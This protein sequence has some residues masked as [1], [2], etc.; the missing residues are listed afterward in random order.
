MIEVP[1]NIHDIERDRKRFEAGKRKI[2]SSDLILDK[3]K[4]DFENYI[5]KKRVKKKVSYGRLANTCSYFYKFCTLFFPNRDLAQL[6]EE[7]YIMMCANLED[8]VFKTEKEKKYSDETISTFK[9][10]FRAYMRVVIGRSETENRFEEFDIKRKKINPKANYLKYEEVKILLDNI[11]FEDYEMRF[12][13]AFMF[14]TG[15]RSQDIRNLRI[16]DIYIDDEGDLMVAFPELKTIGRDIEI[17]EFKPQIEFYL[18]YIKNEKKRNNLD[19]LIS[20]KN[21]KPISIQV[22]NR[23]LKNYSIST[24]GESYDW[25]TSHKLR[26]SSAV[27][28]ASKLGMTYQQYCKKFGWESNSS[29]PALYY[30]KNTLGKTKFKEVLG[31]SKTPVVMVG[32]IYSDI[33]AFEDFGLDL[34]EE[35]FDVWL[36]EITG[37]PYSEN[38]VP[39]TYQDLE[40]YYVP[41]LLGG[42]QYYS[43]ETQVNYIGHSNGCRSALTSLSKYYQGLNDIGYAFDYATGNWISVDLGSYPVDKFFGIAC[44]TTLNEETSVSYYQ[45]KITLSNNYLGDWAIE[46]LSNENKVNIYQDEYVSLVS[47]FSGSKD[48]KI[49]L[50]LQDF[51][52][53]L[54]I[55]K[56]SSFNGNQSVANK[57]L[58]FAGTD[59]IFIPIPHFNW[60]NNN[61]DGVV[62]IKDLELLNNSFLNS[63]LYFINK[64]HRNIIFDNTLNN[65]IEEEL[66]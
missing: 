3:N 56:T 17:V 43:G 55:D 5:L 39:Y 59:E 29:T 48:N 15:C 22:L 14:S 65:I 6:Q 32:G 64:N 38:N 2:M 27:Y 21:N 37:G 40:D 28:F 52:N 13:I 12:I 57:Y 50:N 4:Q 18:H 33:T 11:P 1:V 7:D 66:K 53:D 46:K 61:D 8:G 35:G 42:V 41:A 26:H 30:D 47:P 9:R 36:I 51:Y 25:V 10:F 60:N 44:P 49:S 62:P 63:E 24:F 16:K 58:F 20:Y 34:I 23:K 31:V 45:R 54:A 19:Y